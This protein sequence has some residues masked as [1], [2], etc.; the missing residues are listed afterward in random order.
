MGSSIQI[1]LLVLPPMVVIGWIVGK[2]M[3]L[4][5]E[6][7]EVVALLVASFTTNLASRLA[8]LFGREWHDLDG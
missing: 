2:D 8:S 4:K 1:G 7:F 5:F 3:T 6:T